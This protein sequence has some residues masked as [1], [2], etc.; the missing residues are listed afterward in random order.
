MGINK[1]LFSIF[2]SP[3]LQSSLLGGRDFRCFG[4]NETLETFNALS[5]QIAV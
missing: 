3:V 4:Q 1:K 5:N 2:S